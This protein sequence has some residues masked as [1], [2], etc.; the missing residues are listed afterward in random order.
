M[1]P[2][3]DPWGNE[4]PEGSK[5]WKMAG[6]QIASQYRAVLEGIQGD[7]DFIRILFQPNRLL[8][9]FERF[10]VMTSGFPPRK[11]RLYVRFFVGV[12]LRV[13]PDLARF[14]FQ[15]TSLLLLQSSCMG[16]C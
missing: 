13:V 7:Q 5:R 4:F 8:I 9:P 3:V 15:A 2:S 11:M 10:F 12:C 14:L 6:R 16:V 1:Y